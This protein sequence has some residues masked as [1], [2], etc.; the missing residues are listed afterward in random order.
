[1]SA[2][3]AESSRTYD[4]ARVN[5]KGDGNCFFRSLYEAAKFHTDPKVLNQLLECFGVDIENNGSNTN[6]A[7]QTAKDA[8]EEEDGF[9]KIGRM[10]ITNV[11]R[12]N[13]GEILD[14]LA[15][16]VR[17]PY[18]VNREYIQFLIQGVF[19]SLDNFYTNLIDDVVNDKIKPNEGEE[20]TDTLFRVCMSYF[21]PS[22]PEE[23]QRGLQ[24]GILRAM[25]ALVGDTEGS[26]TENAAPLT[27]AKIIPYLRQDLRISTL[28]ENLRN[29]IQ[30]SWDTYLIEMPSKHREIFGNILY[31]PNSR[32]EY[33]ERIACVIGNENE[34]TAEIDIYIINTVLAPCKLVVHPLS[35]SGPREVIIPAGFRA[36]YVILDSDGEHYNFLVTP[37]IYEK[38]MKLLEGLAPKSKKVFYRRAELFMASSDGIEDHPS[39]PIPEPVKRTGTTATR[40]TANNLN[41]RVKS[42]LANMGINSTSENYGPMYSSIEQQLKDQTATKGGKRRATRKK[43]RV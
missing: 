3:A 25:E 24:T 9:C 7:T 28:P 6:P 34:F 8:R 35:T 38:H 39:K 11:L 14:R 36:L 4:W 31:F 20:L 23:V 27:A 21:V 17:S 40:K 42:T 22:I 16:G 19:E 12:T 32:G 37:T 10:I 43:R 30:E 5:V 18:T 26:N 1:M 41:A 33:A 2:V 29:S 15:G 13:S